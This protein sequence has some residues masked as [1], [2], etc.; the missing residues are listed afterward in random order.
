MA[1]VDTTTFWAVTFDEFEAEG[2]AIRVG[3][4]RAVPFRGEGP[5]W[6]AL[7]DGAEGPHGEA[8]AGRQGAVDFLVGRLLEAVTQ[9]L[10]RAPAQIDK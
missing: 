7:R 10:R 1:A 9:G 8:L 2:L 6:L 3:P 4:W 5:N